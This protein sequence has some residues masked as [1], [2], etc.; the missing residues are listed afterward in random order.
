M[1]VDAELKYLVSLFD[2]QDLCVVDAVNKSII[3]RGAD[4]LL[5]IES[6]LSKEHDPVRRKTILQRMSFFN[7][8]FIIREIEE[9]VSVGAHSL[10]EGGYLLSALLTFGLDREEFRRIFLKNSA[11]YYGE[12]NSSVDPMADIK[13]FNNVFFNVLKYSSIEGDVQSESNALINEVLQSKVGNPIAISFIYFMLA[14]EVGIAVYPLCFPGGFIPSYIDN[15]A[16]LFLINI[17]KDGELF[18][19]DRLKGILENQGYH[20][21]PKDFK[22]RDERAVCVMYLESLLYYYTGQQDQEKHSIIDRALNCF[23]DE[24]YLTIDEDSGED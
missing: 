2:D 5:D 8:E 11:H 20:I 3:K 19:P 17:A 14:Q 13:A 10:F 7:T 22:V 16:V 12:L 6:I 15:G 18:G 9:F 21:D 23:G 1:A 4:V 24:R